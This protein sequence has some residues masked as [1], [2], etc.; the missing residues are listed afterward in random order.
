MSTRP[1]AG[2]VAVLGRPAVNRMPLVALVFSVVALA[3][4]GAT[5][6]FGVLTGS[7]ESAAPVLKGPFGVSQDIP[8]SFGAIAIDN[9]DKLDGMKPKDLNG[10]TH[11]PSY[12]KPDQTQVQASVTMTNL[13]GR[14]VEYSPTQFRLLVG[15]DRKPVDEVRASFRPGTLQPDANIGGQLK[16]VAPREGKKL[17]LEFR[18]PGR[19]TPI[20]IDLG[21]TGT[22]PDSAWDGFHKGH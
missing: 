3:A 4:A 10:M 15:D 7:G 20:L 12:V 6:A 8:T 18:D 13:L 19:D 9:V 21:R 14:P 17:W 22:T 5:L 1:L 11:F 16:F 2:D